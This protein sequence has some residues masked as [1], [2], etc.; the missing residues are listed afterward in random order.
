MIDKELLEVLA[1]PICK[2]EVRLE[3]DKI[4]CTECGRR[5]PIQ[6]DIPVMLPDDAEMPGEGGS[7]GK[8]E[9]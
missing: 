2:V 4:V 9:S 3:G 1:C 8:A 5:Y 7:E 6:G